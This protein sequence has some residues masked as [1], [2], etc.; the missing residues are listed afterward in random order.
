MILPAALVGLV[1][2]SVNHLLLCVVRGLAERRRPEEV[3]ADYRWLWQHY[4][5]LGVL[6]VV[7][8]AGYEA[9]GWTGAA[10]LM[11]PVGMMHLAI[12][13]Y[14][15]RTATSLSE[16]RSLNEQLA[17][18]IV[19]RQA[20]EQENVRLAHD[21]ARAAA[22]DELSRLKSEF[23]SI[24]S[25]EL[26]TPLTTVMG[27]TELLLHDPST[28]PDVRERWLG[29]VH[30]SSQQLTGLVDNLLDVSR[31]EMGRMTIQ[32]AAVDLSAV[33]ETVLEPVR[34]SLKTHAL[35]VD[36]A[37][38]ARLVD[39]DPEKVRQ[40]LVNL[41]SN[42]IKYSPSGGEVAI[43][44]R[45]DEA[46]GRVAVA[47]SDQGIG[48][49]ADQLELIFDRFQRV[50]AAATRAIRGTGLGLYIVRQL[51]ELHGGAIGV[52]SEVGRGST[53][54]FTLPAARST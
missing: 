1:Y 29:I 5:V 25:H 46:S 41:V 39:A 44:A 31:I 34:G 11:A 28:A 40:I 49:P 52:E 14:A 3:W 10:A 51:I 4:L 53:F 26:R 8:A 7:V 43:V 18:E 19:H 24:A 33:V 48:I 32:P 54:H 17:A 9:F 50:N 35:V 22:L 12:K 36:L 30:R 45:R 27:Y 6:A 21:A 37:P 20:A 38:D 2:Y 15:E 23:I 16:L 13:Q 42:A 47:V